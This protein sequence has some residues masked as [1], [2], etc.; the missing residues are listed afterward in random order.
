MSM[1]RIGGGQNC[2]NNDEKKKL[3]LGAVEGKIVRLV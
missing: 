1:F 2:A 3:H